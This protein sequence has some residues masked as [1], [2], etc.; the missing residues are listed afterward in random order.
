MGGVRWGCNIWGTVIKIILIHLSIEGVYCGIDNGD[1]TLNISS[2]KAGILILIHVWQTGEDHINGHTLKLYSNAMY[3][4]HEFPARFPRVHV[5]ASK[6][7]NYEE[8]I[9]C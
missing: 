9:C 4:G 8:A 3:R 7:V 2:H 1:I 6:V 5:E